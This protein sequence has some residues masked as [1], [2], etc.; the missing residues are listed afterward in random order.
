[1]PHP[2]REAYDANAERYA[3]LFLDELDRDTQSIRW[4]TTF[5]AIAA[6]RR[7]R[8]VDLGCGPGSVVRFLSGLGLAITGVDVSSGQIAHSLR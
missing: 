8:I 3:S 1:M 5:A 6:E 4:L 2:V 7:G